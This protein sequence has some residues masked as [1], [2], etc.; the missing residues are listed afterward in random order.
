MSML[1]VSTPLVASTVYVTMVTLE[2]EQSVQVSYL[3]WFLFDE[4]ERFSQSKNPEYH[5]TVSP[6]T[7][8]MLL[9]SL[10]RCG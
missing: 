10:D 9:L 2:V 6:L 1:S 8:E 3:I 5:N 7:T 4:G